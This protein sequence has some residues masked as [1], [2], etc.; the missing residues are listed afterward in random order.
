MLAS[1]SLNGLVSLWDVRNGK[2]EAVFKGHTK[3]IV[4]I[5][6]N[7]K[8]YTI[9][10]ASL[11]GSLTFWGYGKIMPSNLKYKSYLKLLVTDR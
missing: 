10:S 3:E 2:F 1:G 4:S 6:F 9:V 11:D 7:L 5:S 8:S